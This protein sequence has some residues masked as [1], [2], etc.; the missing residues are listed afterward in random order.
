MS[1][2]PDARRADPLVLRWRIAVVLTVISLVIGSIMLA[3][4]SGFGR[5]D[6]GGWVVG[7]LV[8]PVVVGA[9]LEYGFYRFKIRSS[10]KNDVP[11][12]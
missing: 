1:V 11:P 9:W 8:M 4:F 7:I 2:D 10:D 12:I 5:P 3:I 6:V